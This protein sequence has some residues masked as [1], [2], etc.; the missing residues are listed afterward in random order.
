[1]SS[2]AVL[3][4]AIRTRDHDHPPA[5][6]L[7]HPHTRRIPLHREVEHRSAKR[8]S[9][10]APTAGLHSTS[11]VAVGFAG[12]ARRGP[13]EARPFAAP[14]T[15]EFLTMYRSQETVPSHL[16]T[17]TMFTSRASRAHIWHV[18][19]VAVLG[20]RARHKSHITRH[21]NNIALWRHNPHI[22]A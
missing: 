5:E 19:G 8:P 21:I 16:Y 11:V 1:M 3:R 12:R 2:S 13:G 6:K 9:A 18:G 14:R 20:C 15:G 7:T 17:G 22:N 10:G 4:G